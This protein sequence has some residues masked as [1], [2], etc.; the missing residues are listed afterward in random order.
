MKCVKTIK[1]ISKQ[2][3]LFKKFVN[4]FEQEHIIKLFY[5][6]LMFYLN[7]NIFIKFEIFFSV[8]HPDRLYVITLYPYYNSK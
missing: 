2:W 1:P 8:K 3:Q 4:I 5:R 6:V 7:K